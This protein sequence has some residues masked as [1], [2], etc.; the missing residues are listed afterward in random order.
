MWELMSPYETEDSDLEVLAT[1]YGLNF[2]KLIQEISQVRDVMKL[3]NN[4]F[5]SFSNMAHYV[6]TKWTSN[7]IPNLTVL[8]SI[9]LVMPFA[10]ADCERSFSSMNRIKSSRAVKVEGYFEQSHAHLFFAWTE[11]R[12]YGNKE[13]LFQESQRNSCP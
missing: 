6:L 11:R 13:G 2:V 5:T 7:E 8:L 3:G 12:L 1:T 9:A 4:R 10:T